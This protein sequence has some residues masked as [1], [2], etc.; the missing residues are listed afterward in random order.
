MPGNSDAQLMITLCLP[1]HAK[2]GRTQ[3]LDKEWPELLRIL[4]R[5]HHPEGHEQT[6][7]DFKTQSPAAVPV[8]LFELEVPKR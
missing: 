3:F 4:W 2:V 7:I 8:L 5:E 1:Y 6:N